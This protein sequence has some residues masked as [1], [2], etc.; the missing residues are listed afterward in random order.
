MNE[1]LLQTRSLLVKHPVLWLPTLCA[2]ALSYMWNQLGAIIVHGLLPW[3]LTTHSALGGEVPDTS[4]LRVV[5]SY[6]VSFLSKNS[7]QYA[8]I[9]CFV[10]AMLITAK[11]AGHATAKDGE[12]VPYAGLSIS[13][14]MAGALRLGLIAYLLAI[15]AS[16]PVL[17]PFMY[18]LQKEN[19]LDA[20]NQLY[21]PILATACIYAMLAYFLTPAAI[22]LLISSIG[23][24]LTATKISTARIC[25]LF[26]AAAIMILAAIQVLAPRPITHTLV[27]RALLAILWSVLVALPYAPLFVALSL[28]AQEN[29]EQTTA[30]AEANPLRG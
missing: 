6:A 16:G 26:A 21:V 5:T 4:P 14:C 9:C 8:D 23:R 25:S 10:A 12:I 15:A 11:M 2:A 1:L 29:E 3:I 20:V 24:P 7:C 18:Y 17:V 22:R 30:S 13:S 27:Q 28:L 19:R